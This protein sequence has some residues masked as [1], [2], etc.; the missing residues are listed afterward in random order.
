MESEEL[1]EIKKLAT[2]ARKH[3][4]DVEWAIECL[5]EIEVLINEEIK[6][7]PTLDIG[8]I[9]YNITNIN[10]ASLFETLI[11]ILDK[12]SNP[13]KIEELLKNVYNI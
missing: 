12:G 1:K 6:N 13:I 10:E 4:E 3:L 7:K 9:K 8:K 5:E 11:Q 2:N